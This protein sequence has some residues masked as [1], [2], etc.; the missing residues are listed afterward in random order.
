V[1]AI[2][3]LLHA[4]APRTSGRQTAE[5]LL[6]RARQTISRGRATSARA[7]SLKILGDH[8]AQTPQ[9]LAQ[10]AREIDALLEQDPGVK[11]LQSVPAFGVTTVAVLRAEL[12]AV[13]R[14]ARCEQASAYVGWDLTIKDSGQ[15]RGHRKRSKRGSGRLRRMLYMA[16]VRCVRLEGSAFGAYSH[17]LIARGMQRRVA[18]IAVMRKMRAVA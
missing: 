14:F 5:Q 4:L 3:T 15:W 17:R 18:L 11:G 1:E 9:N 13:E 16:A 10:L 12:G 6:A 2:T 7:T 8:L